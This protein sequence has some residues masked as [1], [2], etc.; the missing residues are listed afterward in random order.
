MYQGFTDSYGEEGMYNCILLPVYLKPL[1][2]IVSVSCPYKNMICAGQTA[3][4][5]IISYK[6]PSDLNFARCLAIHILFFVI[7]GVY[8]RALG[9]T[10]MEG[11]I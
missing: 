7:V 9:T 5:T 8:E 10:C 4:V 2:K 3:I 6:P 11:V 1:I